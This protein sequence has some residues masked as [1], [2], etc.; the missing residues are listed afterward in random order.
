MTRTRLLLAAVFVLSAP[1]AG[2]A[3][4]PPVRT[5]DYPGT[6]AGHKVTFSVQEVHPGGL[7]DVVGEHLEGGSRGSS[8]GSAESSPGTAR[9]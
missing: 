5:G 8:S 7:F 1:A 4:P 3:A 9:W 2:A 6:W